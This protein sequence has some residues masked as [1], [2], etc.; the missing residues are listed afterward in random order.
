VAVETESDLTRG[1]TVVDLY[2]RTGNQ[3]NAK[4]AVGIDA[5]G[6]LDLLEERI[7]ALG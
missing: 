1:R 3:P 2:R 5:E 6:F 4:V 7:A